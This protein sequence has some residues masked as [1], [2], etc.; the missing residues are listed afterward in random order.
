MEIILWLGVTTAR[1][2]ALKGRSIR[3][4]ES[5]CCRVT[6]EAK[7]TAVLH[8]CEQVHPCAHT[9]RNQGRAMG[10]LLS[11]LMDSTLV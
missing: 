7:L 1:G 3:K 2:T 9:H 6:E 8:T 5:H 10:R 4:V 11:L